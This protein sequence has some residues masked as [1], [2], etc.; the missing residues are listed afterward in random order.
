[1]EQTGIHV[2][3]QL[4]INSIFFCGMVAVEIIILFTPA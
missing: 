4:H 2:R 3:E 1:M